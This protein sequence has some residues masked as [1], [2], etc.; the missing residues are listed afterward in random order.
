MENN[1]KFRNYI[2]VYIRILC[3]VTNH[4]TL[5]KIIAKCEIHLRLSLCKSMQ[6]LKSRLLNWVCNNK[7]HEFS[8]LCLTS[9]E[10]DV[11]MAI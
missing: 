5:K 8:K 3:V 4:E 2:H 11:T 7:L 6:Y 10:D 9:I 1:I